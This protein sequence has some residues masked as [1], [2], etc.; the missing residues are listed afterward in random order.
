V[1][2]HREVNPCQSSA[3]SEDE[4]RPNRGKRFEDAL[5]KKLVELTHFSSSHLFRFSIATAK[6]RRVAMRAEGVHVP[7]EGV[8]V[9]AGR[10]RVRVGSGRVRAEG[11]R[12]HA[13]RVRVCAGRV[14]ACA[15]RVRVRVG[16]VRAPAGRVREHAGRVREHAG[17]LHER[18]GQQVT[19]RFRLTYVSLGLILTVLGARLGRTSPRAATGETT[20]LDSATDLISAGVERSFSC[21]RLWK[22]AHFPE[23]S[24]G[25]AGAS[26]SPPAGG[27]LRPVHEVLVVPTG[28]TFGR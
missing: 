13:G 24:T 4:R 12:V 17:G 5:L 20:A 25:G 22:C 1:P 3:A 9:L 26:P 11:V 2:L 21:R 10:V 27:R 15:G 18:A 19:Y 28:H 16:R 14:R 23:T 8:H 6:R 7:A